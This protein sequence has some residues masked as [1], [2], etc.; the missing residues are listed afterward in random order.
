MRRVDHRRVLAEAAAAVEQLDRTYAV[1]CQ[2]L[3]ALARLLVG[4]DVQRQ[5]IRA[6]VVAD[7]LQP[8][9]GARTHRMRGDTDADTAF[10]EVVHLGQVVRD[11]VL[12]R[13]GETTARIG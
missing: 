11:G 8:I 4:M 3:F 12:S 10:A 7:C 5:T 9:R 2:T 6:P 1:L 13:A